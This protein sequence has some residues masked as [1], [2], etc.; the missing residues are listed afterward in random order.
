VTLAS[1]RALLLIGEPGTGK[2]VK[3]DTLVVDARTGRRV[4]IE[5][6]CRTRDVVV[7]SLDAEYRLEPNS[8]GATIAAVRSERPEYLILIDRAPA[9]L[10]RQLSSQ[11][12]RLSFIRAP[13]PVYGLHS[14]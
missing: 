7:N 6:V 2:C 5:E 8:E 10:N 11:Y 12:D 4:R 14:G 3:G 1:E 13:W 9:A